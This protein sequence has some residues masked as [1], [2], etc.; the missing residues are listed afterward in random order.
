MAEC[1]QL[2]QYHTVQVLE[3]IHTS[4]MLCKAMAKA[5]LTPTRRPCKQLGNKQEWYMTFS[6]SS[7]Y[8]PQTDI[9]NHSCCIYNH[10][11]RMMKRPCKSKP[12]YSRRKENIQECMEWHTYLAI[13]TS[14]YSYE[15]KKKKKTY[16][17]GSVSI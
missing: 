10:Q 7:N 17:P 8:S 9:E 4:G 3:N 13:S 12:I 5:K 6:I 11:S 1:E 16:K 2:E 15:I 14:I